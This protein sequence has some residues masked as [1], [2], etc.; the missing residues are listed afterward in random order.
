LAGNILPDS[1]LGSM[2]WSQFSAI[3]DNFLQFSTIFRDFRQFSAKYGVFLKN[4]CYGHILDYFSFV[5]S[6]NHQFI[7]KFF[8]ENFKIT[9]S[10]PDTY[11]YVFCILPLFCTGDQEKRII[12]LKKERKKRNF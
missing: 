10:F 3:F 6:Q 2:L 9:T 4:Q 11:I 1:N 8:E 7:A 5:L 12:F